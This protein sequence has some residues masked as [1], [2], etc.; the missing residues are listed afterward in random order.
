VQFFQ[1][2]FLFLIT[3][4]ITM[5]SDYSSY[6]NNC[7]SNVVVWLVGRSVGVSAPAFVM[8]FE[9]LGIC[10]IEWNMI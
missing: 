8:L 1:H 4:D 3:V 5:W 6:Q 10:S 2:K 7:C 9:L